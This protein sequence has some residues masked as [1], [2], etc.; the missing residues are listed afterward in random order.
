MLSSSWIRNLLGS[1]SRSTRHGSRRA[2]Q[3][4]GRTCLGLETLED[5]TVPAITASFTDGG[6]LKVDLSAAN[7]HAEVIVDNTN[8][9]VI[10]NDVNGGNILTKSFTTIGN[11]NIDG[12]GAV[13]QEVDLRAQGGTA[14]IT[15]QITVDGINHLDLE[16]GK[17]SV[18]TTLTVNLTGTGG[19]GFHENGTGRIT[20]NGDTSLNAGANNISL[21]NDND[22][23]GNVSIG[24]ATDVTLVDTTNLKLTVL[25]IVNSAAIFSNDIA[26]NGGA[27]NYH[28]DNGGEIQLAPN[29]V[30]TS[31]GIAG[32]AGTYALSQ[33]E[34]TNL[35]FD[36]SFGLLTIGRDDGQ[37]VITI[38]AVQF[39]DP[40]VI[41]APVTAGSITVNGKI[42]GLGDASITLDGPDGTTTLNAGISTEGNNIKI[43]DSV[44]LGTPGTVTLDTTLNGFTNGA[45]IRITGKINDD[46]TTSNLSLNAGT[47]GDINLSGVGA[48]TPIG[49]LTIVNAFDATLSTVK[50]AKLVQNAG[51][52][53]TKLNGNVT[54]T[55]GGNAVDLT[56][57][58]IFLDA[59][60][61][62]T[63]TVRLNP[64][65]TGVFQNSGNITALNL[66]LQGTGD[67]TLNSSGND[68]DVLAGNPTGAITFQDTDTLTIGTVGGV[69]GLKS[70]NKAITI[71]TNDTLT[72]GTGAGQDIN[73][74][75]GDVTLLSF[76]G[77]TANANSGVLANKLTLQ[78]FGDF[79]LGNANGS[80][81]NLLSANLGFGNINYRDVNALTVDPAGIS[82]NG[83]DVRLQ[84]GNGFVLTVNGVI[85]TKP[86]S[87]GAYT[88]IGARRNLKLNV[89]PQ[90]GSGDIT[91]IFPA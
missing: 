38:N 14:N 68:V 19:G 9:K 15:N 73:A 75:T 20:V 18:G 7:D 72:I 3:W 22:F 59:N 13:N 43:D 78:G 87:G 57:N 76:N 58:N 77:V 48:T 45:D 91:L 83:G 47:G 82:T 63:A 56:T 71:I 42:Q 5:R 6:E 46:G 88:A 27:G 31:I 84:T 70:N 86:G 26:L 69:A 21:G 1:Q 60:V 52:G 81:V 39:N 25:N 61:S 10:V 12:N 4:S 90:V 41:Q 23:Q 85:S 79:N 49:N 33:T 66:L 62:S 17:Y 67:F 36:D 74:G 50:S 30:G 35:L 40:T 16:Q 55:G 54:V 80:N 24:G 28:S 34:I 11:V 2:S 29:L 53:T 64:S 65:G 37:H 44:V 32:A 51:G 8:S 89:A